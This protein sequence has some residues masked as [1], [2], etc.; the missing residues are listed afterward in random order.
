MVITH[1]IADLANTLTA[2][3][4]DKSNIL[5]PDRAPSAAGVEN[6]LLDF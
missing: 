5:I 1:Y 6:D 2:R 4:L 3:T